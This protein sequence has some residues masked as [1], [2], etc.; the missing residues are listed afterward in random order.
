VSGLTLTVPQRIEAHRDAFPDRAGH[1]G[2]FQLGR[3]A[4]GDEAL[5]GVVMGGQDYRN[6]SKLYGAYPPS[7]LPTVFS[8]FPDAQRILHLFSGSLT[9]EQV[10]TAWPLKP[11][12]PF[13][14]GLKR[15]PAQP[16]QLRFDNGRHPIAEAARP[17]VIGDAEKLEG[18]MQRWS[19]LFL[20]KS[21]LESGPKVQMD[22]IVA[23]PAYAVSDQRRYWFESMVALGDCPRCHWPLVRHRR[24]FYKSMGEGRLLCDK[25]ALVHDGSTA[26][27]FSEI[28]QDKL[29]CRHQNYVRFKPL[30]KKKVLAECA[31]VLAPGGFLVWLDCKLPAW[32]GRATGGPWIYRGGFALIRSQGHR[33]R[34]A[35]LLERAP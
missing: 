4:H 12:A 16:V 27:T 11:G 31:K 25:R 32:K 23:D 3:T 21:N 6:K 13:P 9:A 2:G 10:A 28:S 26:L 14:S 20:A 33:I 15:E 22:L 34:F 8:L 18:E 35:T 30:N 5:Y 7:Y 24:K 1:G 17:D 29:E 19:D